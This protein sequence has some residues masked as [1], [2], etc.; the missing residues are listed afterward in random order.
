L[1]GLFSLRISI[2]AMGDRVTF[3]GDSVTA[4]RYYTCD[5]QDF[6]ETRYATLQVPITYQV[7]VDY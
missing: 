3:S 6:V 2:F 7:G 5:I 1:E 4:Q